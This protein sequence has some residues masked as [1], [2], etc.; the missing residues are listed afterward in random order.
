MAIKPI[1]I[2]IGGV[3]LITLTGAALIYNQYK[4]LMDGIKMSFN[5]I[6]VSSITAKLIK[7]DLYLNFT[8]KSKLYFHI[9]EQKYTVYVNGKIISVAKNY[10]NVPVVAESDSIVPVNVGLYPDKIKKG[11]DI[12]SGGILAAL[13]NPSGTTLKVDTELTIKIWGMKIKIPKFSYETDLKKLMSE[14][15]AK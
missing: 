11:L 7:F 10:N 5:A 13:I 15:K 6:R 4:K 12:G 2:V 9:V 14:P 1:H 8:N 3:A